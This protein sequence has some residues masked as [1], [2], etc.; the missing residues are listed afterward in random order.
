MHCINVCVNIR[1]SAF[2]GGCARGP[3]GPSRQ[4]NGFDF[5]K[6]E[7]L[8]RAPDNVFVFRGKEQQV[9]GWRNVFE[10][11]IQYDVELCPGLLS[12]NSSTLSFRFLPEGGPR[13]RFVVIGETETA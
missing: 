2:G 4:L 5:A 6:P 12:E 13:R 10:L 1:F 11:P 3:L 7:P 8:L 9:L